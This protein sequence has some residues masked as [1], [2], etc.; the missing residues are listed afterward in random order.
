MSKPITFILWL[1]YFGWCNF[2][3]KF[4]AKNF[5]V[6]KLLGSK[7]FLV[8]K[9]L[10]TKKKLGAKIFFVAL[11]CDCFEVELGLRQYSVIIMKILY[12]YCGKGLIKYYQIIYK[13]C[14]KTVQISCK[15]C[16]NFMK[17][18]W[19]HAKVCNICKNAAKRSRQH[20][21]KKYREYA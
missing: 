19:N 14:A 18:S 10:F 17:K 3:T 13:Y 9:Y 20:A 4:F 21:G 12:K 5:S 8:K 11:S 1:N 15:Y 16:A 7:D 2:C 6:K